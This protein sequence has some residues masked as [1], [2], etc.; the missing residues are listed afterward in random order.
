MSHLLPTNATGTQMGWSIIDRNSVTYSVG[1]SVMAAP[2]RSTR[3]HRPGETDF[4]AQTKAPR[5]SRNPKIPE[6]LMTTLVPDCSAR[7]R[8]LVT[9]QLCTAISLPV[10]FR[11]CERMVTAEWLIL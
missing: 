4:L 5:A 11:R 6:I 7:S 3:R 10:P 9:Q 8:S 1:D 2:R